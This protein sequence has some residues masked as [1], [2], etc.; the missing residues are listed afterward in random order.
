MRALSNGHVGRVS[1]SLSTLLGYLTDVQPYRRTGGVG[2]HYEHS[3]SHSTRWL[4]LDNL[5]KKLP[6]LQLFLTETGISPL[7]V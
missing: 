3:V 7:E 5:F 4:C 2:S 6:N 1:G